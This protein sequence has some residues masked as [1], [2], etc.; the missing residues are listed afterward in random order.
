MAAEVGRED[1]PR[2]SL[3][4][5][6]WAAGA[7]G[8]GGLLAGILLASGSLAGASVRPEA[9]LERRG[10]KADGED[11]RARRGILDR[12]EKQLRAPRP[13]RRRR[14][15]AGLAE[16]GGDRA[17]AAV[18]AALSDRSAEVAD[19]AQLRLPALLGS[20]IPASIRRHG[21]LTARSPLVRLRWAELVGRSPS[22][23]E[24]KD[25]AGLMGVRGDAVGRALTWSVERLARRDLIVGDPAR[26]VQRLVGRAKSGA[27]LG[28]RAAALQALLPL[29][30][31]RAEPFVRPWA[32]SD[33]R[34]L[35]CS[36]LMAAVELGLP[37]A[38][39]L[40]EAGVH[41]A[42]WAVRL[43]AIE[44]LVEVGG[45]SALDLLVERLRA[46]SRAAL[47][48]ELVGGL[49]ALTGLWH[50]DHPEAWALALRGLPSDWTAPSPA[51]GREAAAAPRGT[52]AAIGRLDPRSD[53]LAILVDFSGSLWNRDSQGR[54]KKDQLDPQV[55]QLLAR[56]G[57]GTRF[58]LVPYTG[59]PHPFEPRLV[60]ATRRN[61][62]RAQRFFTSAR[63]SGSGDLFGALSLALDSPEVDRVVLLTDGAPSGGERWDIALMV[64][65]LEERL[66][67]R[68]AVLDFILVDSS[69]KLVRQWGGLAGSTGGDVLELAW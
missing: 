36:A 42:D 66:R 16:L 67:F 31:D 58:L 62:A 32:E 37:D 44:L 50:R 11:E 5:G 29:S 43:R 26:L 57:A 4:W 28:S 59:E 65:L 56:L 51:S 49:Q 23:L 6:R 20:S 46:E 38:V 24:A 48:G 12:L 3:A 47:R 55:A 60:E 14:A 17:T 53:R 33:D 41:H 9:G 2:R 52:V 25:L 18:I 15:V 34:E 10:V 64:T 40:L 1:G 22:P 54:C 8:R 69:P 61:V 35:C 19:V 30:P 13:E 63:M 27:D 21:G 7:L 39:A 68:P 45:T